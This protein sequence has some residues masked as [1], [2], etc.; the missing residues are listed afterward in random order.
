MVQ[1]DWIDYIS[2]KPPENYIE[3]LNDYGWNITY[4]AESDPNKVFAGD[5]VL[6]ET[7]TQQ[8]TEAFLFGAAITLFVLPESIQESI[9]K[10]VDDLDRPINSE[11]G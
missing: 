6:I 7:E 10:F 4:D 5:R 8:E 1:S 9:K 11:R 2:G 3:L